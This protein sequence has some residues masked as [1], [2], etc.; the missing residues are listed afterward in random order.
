MLQ[1]CCFKNNN[2]E[3]LNVQFDFL[4]IIPSVHT[5]RFNEIMSKMNCYFYTKQENQWVCWEQLLVDKIEECLTE[6]KALFLMVD[7][8]N[9]SYFEKRYCTHATC[10]IINEGKIHYINPHG[11]SMKYINEYRVQ[12]KRSRDI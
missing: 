8:I 7:I 11:D 10:I 2:I 4:D 12:T 1:Q 5:P 3:L 6:K 9:Y